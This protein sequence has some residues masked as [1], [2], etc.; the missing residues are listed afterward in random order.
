VLPRPVFDSRG[1]AVGAGV[2]FF[3][4]LVQLQKLFGA[5]VLAPLASVEINL[6]LV[7]NILK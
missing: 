1:G 5:L 2:K 6:V 4:H 3:V 7:Q